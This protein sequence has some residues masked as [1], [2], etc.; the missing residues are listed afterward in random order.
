L[1]CAIFFLDTGCLPCASIFPKLGHVSPVIAGPIDRRLQQER[2]SRQAL[3]RRRTQPR[4]SEN[5]RESLRAN[6]PLPY[7]LVAVDAST[8]RNFRIVYVE[9]G[10][11]IEADAL[12]DQFHRG[13]QPALALDVVPRGK[14]MRRIEACGC[15]QAGESADDVADF[16]QPRSHRRSHASRIFDQDTQHTERNASCRLLHRFDDRR[17]GP[18]RCGVAA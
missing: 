10:D 5:P 8:Q 6:F 12:I 14:E 4:V 7:V 9:N 18:F 15:L 3:R 17:H 1:L 13:S 11:T 16:F 2:A